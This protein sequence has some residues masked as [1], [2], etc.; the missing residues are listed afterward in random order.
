MRRNDRVVVISTAHGLKFS[1]FKT[2]YHEGTLPGAPPR[3]A[4]LPVSLPAEYGAVRDAVLGAVERARGR[5]T[6]R[7]T[8]GGGRG[9]TAA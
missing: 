1:E 3:Q 6:L 8:A 7:G 5:E 9:G 4:N 2:R